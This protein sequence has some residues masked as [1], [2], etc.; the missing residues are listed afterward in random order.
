VTPHAPDLPTI[1]AAIAVPCLDA[2]QR[3]L[4][5]LR[6]LRKVHGWLGLW[7]AVFGF[8]FGVTGIIMAHR[9]VLKLPVTKGEQRVVQMRIERV[10][11]TPGEL[12]QEISNRFGFE[13]RV[14]RIVT[15]PARPVA[16][17]GVG[18]TQPER[19][20]LHFAHP[21]RQ[22]KI[23]YF[24]GSGFARVEKFD[25]TWIGTLT[26]LHMATGVDAMWVLLLDTIAA[27]LIVLSLTGTLMWSQLRPLRLVGALVVLGAPAI[28]AGWLLMFL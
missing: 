26:R 17:N 1:P 22:A 10:P 23:E 4:A 20:E 27:S 9:A 15:E 16:W 2:R 8:L 7:A 11:T 21:Q 25:A 28:A 13:G 3:R 12:A 19:W 6:W 14:P 24:V 18:L 5:V